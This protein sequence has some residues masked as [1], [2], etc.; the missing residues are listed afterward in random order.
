MPNRKY[1]LGISQLGALA[2]GLITLMIVLGFA[3]LV[4]GVMES[5]IGKIYT[6]QNV[7]TDWTNIASRVFGFTRTGLGILSIGVLIAVF[8][9]ILVLVRYLGG[10]E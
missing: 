3:V 2:I 9:A 4:G 7:T 10:K 8:G 1:S 5:E 6:E